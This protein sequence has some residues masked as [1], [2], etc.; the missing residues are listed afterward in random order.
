MLCRVLGPCFTLCKGVR[1]EDE[2]RVGDREGEEKGGEKV[3]GN[4]ILSQNSSAQGVV[5]MVIYH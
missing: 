4:R 5:G 1:K 3:N 2:R